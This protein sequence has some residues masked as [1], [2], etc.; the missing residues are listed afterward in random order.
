MIDSP[1]SQDTLLLMGYLYYEVDGQ[2]YILVR[3][4]SRLPIIKVLPHDIGSLS[5]IY[6]LANQTLLDFFHEIAIPQAEIFAAGFYSPELVPLLEIQKSDKAVEPRSWVFLKL[7]LTRPVYSNSALWR[8][9]DFQWKPK[10]V[11]T[12]VWHNDSFVYG[13]NDRLEEEHPLPGIGIRGGPYK[14]LIQDRVLLDL[15][16]RVLDC[17]DMLIFRRSLRRRIEFLL[18]QRKDDKTWEYP[19]GGMEYHESPIEGALREIEE[20]VGFAK[21]ELQYCG[22]LGWQMPDVSYRHKFYDTLR[23]HGLTFHYTGNHPQVDIA[24]MFEHQSYKWLPLAE[25][26]DA[27]S[28]LPYGGEF[29]DRWKTEHPAILSRAKITGKLS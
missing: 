21:N 6:A 17:V 8:E 24:R 3:G 2:E 15:G 25:A 5:D 28:A 14:I 7:R 11:V 18:V 12:R 1:R 13:F 26:K 19:K 10:D 20:E 9:R 23:V 16:R 22:Y 4:D 29:F 27:V